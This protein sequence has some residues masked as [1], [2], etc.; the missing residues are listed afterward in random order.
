MRTRKVGHARWRSSRSRGK[1]SWTKVRLMVEKCKLSEI[2]RRSFPLLNSRRKNCQRTL[3]P[4]VRP[5]PRTH[6]PPCPPPANFPPPTAARSRPI[7]PHP[8]NQPRSDVRDGVPR[9]AEVDPQEDA[10]ACAWNSYA[11]RKGW[12]LQTGPDNRR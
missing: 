8:V 5:R 10:R 11:A 2:Y 3:V 4:T 1:K 6:T 7:S 9:R 12:H